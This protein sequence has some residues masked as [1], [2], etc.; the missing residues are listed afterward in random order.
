ML[1]MISAG[2]RYVEGKD[3]E[4]E[5]RGR[6]GFVVTIALV[7]ASTLGRPSMFGTSC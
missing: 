1:S 4:R 7:T 2:H 3:S 5:L 6:N